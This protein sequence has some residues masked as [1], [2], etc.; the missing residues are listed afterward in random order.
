[1]RS[2]DTPPTCRSRSS[3]TMT[4]CSPTCTMAARSNPS[5]GG[6]S[7]WWCRGAIS[8]RAPS[9]SAGSNSRPT[10]GRADERVTREHY[11]RGYNETRRMLK[12]WISEVRHHGIEVAEVSDETETVAPPEMS[13]AID[14]GDP[15]DGAALT[16]EEQK[17]LE[18]PRAG[19]G[20]RAIAAPTR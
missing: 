7:G 18:L 4:C 13:D 8:G 9:G 3:K 10:T 12:L 19:T 20:G 2:R 11:E 16:H 1:M 17:D 5:T 6:R 15:G 14:L